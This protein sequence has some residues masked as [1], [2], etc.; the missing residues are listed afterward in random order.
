M[1]DPRLNTQYELFGE[2][3]TT[4]LGEH[5]G[6]S[7][8]GELTTQRP[9][10]G[11]ST[12]IDS[13][14]PGAST[15]AYTLATADKVTREEYFASDTA[16][17]TWDAYKGT[18]TPYNAVASQRTISKPQ[19]IEAGSY[20]RE[21]DFLQITD[22]KAP[23]IDMLTR[24]VFRADDLEM[25]KAVTAS[26]VDRY[27]STSPDTISSVALPATQALDD[28]LYADIDVDSL[29]SAIKEKFDD[30]WVANG[31][32]IFCAISS[33]V[34]RM[35]RK[36][37][38]VHSADFVRNFAD[39]RRTGGLPEI[40]GVTFVVMPTSYMGLFTT[41]TD[42]IFAWTPDAIAQVVYSPFKITSDVSGDHRFDVVSYLRKS[43]DYKRVDDRGVVV[44]DI[45]G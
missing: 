31:Q 15:D 39:L 9:G 19:L 28:M 5:P 16:N 42:T 13:L 30:A 44:G 10:E 2:L 43:V 4:A 35:L 41:A 11:K 18:M 45:T 24:K 7:I 33:K 29:P 26:A 36:D 3:V 37:T 27:L 32:P 1:A 6:R 22:P 23:E 25:G 14:D 17:Q 34:A 40:D 8:L 38:T 12:L 20:F 21:E